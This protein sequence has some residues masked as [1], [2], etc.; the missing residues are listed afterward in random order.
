MINDRIVIEH[1]FDDLLK[2][3]PIYYSD[4]EFI[5]VIIEKEILIQEAIKRN[6]NK[7]EPFRASVENF[8]EQSLIKILMDRQ[9]KEFNPDVSEKEIDKYISLTNMKVV[10][11]KMIY[12]KKENIGGGKKE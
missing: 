5:D 7:D 2:T 10:I 1:E 6:I 4:N 3:K 12:E 9:Y 8:Y 11:S